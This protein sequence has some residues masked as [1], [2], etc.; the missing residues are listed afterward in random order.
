MQKYPEGH[1]A[2]AKRDRCNC[3]PLKA[4]GLGLPGTEALHDFSV[5]A[6]HVDSRSSRWHDFAVAKL[7]QS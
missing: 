6:A 2:D 7:H 4:V 5:F 1:Q 3:E